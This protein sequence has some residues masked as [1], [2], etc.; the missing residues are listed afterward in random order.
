MVKEANGRAGRRLHAFN[1]RAAYVP[2][3]MLE[4][5]ANHWLVKSV[6]VDRPTSGELNRIAATIGARYV[7]TTMGYYGRGHWRG[8]PR[9]RHHR[10][11]RRSDNN[12]SAV[13]GS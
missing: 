10:L 5:L 8:G 3:K 4:K 2:E 11:A 6:H 12:G 7:Q 13:S 9:F 1:G